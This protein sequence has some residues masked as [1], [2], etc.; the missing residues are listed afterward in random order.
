M[1]IIECIMERL[2]VQ[3]LYIESVLNVRKLML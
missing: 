3:R 1:G 2:G